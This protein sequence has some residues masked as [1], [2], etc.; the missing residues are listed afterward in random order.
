MAVKSKLTLDS[1]PIEQVS[2][3]NYLDCQLSYQG[4]V[5]VNDNPEKL[6]YT[7][8]T[9]ERRTLKNK[10]KMETHIKFYKVFAVS[11]G[12]YG[13][14]NW[15]LKII[16]A[17]EMKFLRSTM[18]V[19]KQHRLINEAIRKTLNVNS[20]SDTISKYRDNWFNYIRRMDHSPF[21]RYMLSYKPTRKRSLGRP[22]MRWVSQI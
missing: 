20:L 11:A 1:Q 22:R 10:T 9:I 18:G 19:T 15:V 12:L 14:E 2:K 17:A 3:V 5:D 16:Q 6:H 4:E 13:S 8:G 7:C 21:P